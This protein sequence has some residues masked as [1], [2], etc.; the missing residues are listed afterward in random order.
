MSQLEKQQEQKDI[1]FTL[2]YGFKP[3]EVAIQITP[4]DKKSVYMAIMLY[5]KKNDEK[6]VTISETYRWGNVYMDGH[7]VTYLS[8]N[9]V[10]W[11]HHS[12][13]PDFPYPDT[14]LEDL[15]STWFDF[16]GPWTDEEKEEFENIWYDGDP[17]DDNG[18]TSWGWVHD[19]QTDY[20]VEDDQTWLEGCDVKYNIISKKT[21]DWVVQDW[22]PE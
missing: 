22:K 18:Y 14:D 19:Y 5:D 8:N 10:M 17:K 11:H 20:E 3:S 15:C 1:V 12:D 13:I 6:T 7:A 16:D 4:Q 9:T 2:K 21:G